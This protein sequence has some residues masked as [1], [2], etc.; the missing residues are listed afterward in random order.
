MYIDFRY[1]QQTLLVLWQN[2]TLKSLEQQRKLWYA[3]EGGKV[4]VKLAFHV[5]TPPPSLPPCP[6]HHH[7]VE[8]EVWPMRGL[9]LVMWSEGQWEALTKFV[10]VGDIFIFIST[11][12]ATTR[13]NRP[14]WPFLWKVVTNVNYVWMSRKTP[15]KF[16]TP[17]I[18]Q[19]WNATTWSSSYGQLV[20]M[21]CL[22]YHGLL[23]HGRASWVLPEFHCTK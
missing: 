17:G 10:W 15:L 11:D 12:I 9:K 3:C 16:N 2:N 19:A 8:K 1:Q 7:M 23:S 18:T 6:N 20:W 21:N 22:D 4:D 13:P 5:F 14:S